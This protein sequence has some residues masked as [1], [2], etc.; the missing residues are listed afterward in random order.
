MADLYAN[1]NFSRPVVELL[2]ALGHDVLTSIEAGNANQEIPDGEVLR[3]AVSK[4]RTVITFNRA[5]FIQLHKK[6]DAHD[7][8]IVCS[9]D[10]DSASLATR[11]HRK[12]RANEPLGGKLLRVNL[13][14]SE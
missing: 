6:N 10:P 4:R 5:D 9:Q 2:R 8:I 7:G 12:I 3:F 11:V 14:E 1:E 13:I